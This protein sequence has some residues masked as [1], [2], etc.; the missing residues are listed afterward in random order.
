MD[1]SI[2]LCWNSQSKSMLVSAQPFPFCFPFTC[3]CKPQPK[4]VLKLFIT[5]MTIATNF[6]SFITVIKIS[7]P[8]V[9]DDWALRIVMLLTP[10]CQYLC[11][12]QTLLDPPGIPSKAAALMGS[13]WLQTK[14]G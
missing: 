13:L 7:S 2:L 11:V 12:W 8:G 6:I 1:T 5:E 3:L 4:R 14:V 10:Q 9:L